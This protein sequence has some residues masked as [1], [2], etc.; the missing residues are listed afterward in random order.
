MG[1]TLTAAPRNNAPA[2]FLRAR[3][4]AVSAKNTKMTLQAI[5]CVQQP[6]DVIGGN[7]GY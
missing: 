7:I 6:M 1:G 3:F 2:G 5:W 4:F